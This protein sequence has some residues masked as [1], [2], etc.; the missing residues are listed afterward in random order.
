MKNN[1]F[2]YNIFT[3]HHSQGFEFTFYLMAKKMKIKS[4]V[5]KSFFR[6]KIFYSESFEDWGDFKKT[7][8]IFNTTNKTFL[9]KL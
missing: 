4:L 2:T 1:K 6:N 8:A 7:K 3:P 9:K 5:F